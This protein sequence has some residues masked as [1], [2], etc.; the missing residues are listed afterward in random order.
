[1]DSKV[2][3]GFFDLSQKGI[4]VI[5]HSFDCVYWAGTVT[6]ATELASVGV[7]VDLSVI[8]ING[9]RIVRTE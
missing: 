2:F 3:D 8:R 6:Y 7:D 9:D 1:V 4:E 5:V